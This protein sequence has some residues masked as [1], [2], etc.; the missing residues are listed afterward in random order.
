MS[1][2]LTGCFWDFSIFVCGENDQV[3]NGTNLQSFSDKGLKYAN[4]NA[5]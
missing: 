4:N 2:C 1:A 3:V 5:A